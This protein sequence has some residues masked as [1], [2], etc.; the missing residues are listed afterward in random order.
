[1]SAATDYGARITGVEAETR[2]LRRAIDVVFRKV[3]DLG[4]KLDVLTSV[5]HE[6]KATRGPSVQALM[7]M[8]A[9]G[10]VIITAYTASVVWLARSGMSEDM[11]KLRDRQTRMETIMEMATARPRPTPGA[12]AQSY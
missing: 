7:T 4:G 8:A 6:L 10:I 12:W 3:D 5:L 1:M 9:A 2:E 11:Q